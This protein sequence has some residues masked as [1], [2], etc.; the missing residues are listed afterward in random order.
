MGSC[1]AGTRASLRATLGVQL[2]AMGRHDEAA[3]EY[4]A[5]ARALAERHGHERVAHAL[6]A[7]EDE[8]RPLALG[9]FLWESLEA[10]PPP[11]DERI[12]ENV[13]AR[14]GSKRTAPLVAPA[15]RSSRP[16]ST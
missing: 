7:A 10:E 2:H 14:A 1:A 15:R 16:P 8:A 3:E 11:I 4:C 13:A 5:T 6:R 12:R 9:R